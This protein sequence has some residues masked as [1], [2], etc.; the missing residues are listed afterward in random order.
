M[1]KNDSIPASSGTETID[2]FEQLYDPETGGWYMPEWMDRPFDAS[3]VAE[4][5]ATKPLWYSP[6]E[7]EVGQFYRALTAMLRP[8]TV[9]ETGTNAGYSAACIARGLADAGGTGRVVTIDLRDTP[10]IFRGTSLEKLIRFVNA[11]SL[12]VGLDRLQEAAGGVTQFDMLVLDS[13]HRYGS[14]VG[15]INRFAPLLPMGGIMVL[16]DTMVYDGLALVVRD[17]VASGAFEVVN[18]PT[19]R[20]HGNPRGRRPGITVARK[21]MVVPAG[22]L[23]ANPA[24]LE[25]E[26]NLPGRTSDDLSLI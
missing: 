18:L 8:R 4:W 2:A 26:T 15:E 14:L 10:H 19:P 6:V 9:L 1:L 22:F 20:T 25:V 3:Q 11:H 12:H 5:R 17:L 24:L 7:R 16:H 23:V 13:D 21:K